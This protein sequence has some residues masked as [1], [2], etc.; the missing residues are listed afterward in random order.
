VHL[1][2]GHTVEDD[3]EETLEREMERG[4]QG[5]GERKRVLKKGGFAL[6]CEAATGATDA[7]INGWMLL[8]CA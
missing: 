2:G 5:E 3:A 7:S 6:A 1:R 8:I 4:G